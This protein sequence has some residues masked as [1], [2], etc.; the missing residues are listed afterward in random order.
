MFR[1]TRKV[2]AGLTPLRI[3]SPSQVP[4]TTIA[5]PTTISQSGFVLLPEKLPHNDSS[6]PSSDGL[7]GTQTA[8][9]CVSFLSVSVLFIS[10]HKVNFSLITCTR[11]EIHIYIH[12]NNIKCERQESDT[13]GSNF[14]MSA[15]HRCIQTEHN[16]WTCL[17]TTKKIVLNIRKLKTDK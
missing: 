11:F 12:C 17:C 4:T 9:A 7:G 16:A 14:H 2:T 13:A 15:S 3:R 1:Q 6:T 8:M 5:L 10:V